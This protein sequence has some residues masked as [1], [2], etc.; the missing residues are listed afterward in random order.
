MSPAESAFSFFDEGSPHAMSTSDLV[1]ER[2]RA[3]TLERGT[4]GE[5]T[6]AS[7]NAGSQPQSELRRNKS[8]YY[9]EVFSYREPNLSPR[10]R[11][12]KDSVITAEI[13]T[14]VIVRAYKHTAPHPTLMLT[15]LCVFQ[16]TDEINFLQ[17]FSQHLS[18]RYQRPVSSIFITLN[19]SECLLYAGTFDQAYCLTI[20][21]LPSQVLP[22][23]N[24]RNAALIQAFLAESLGVAATRGVVRFISIPEENLAFNGTTVFGQ[25]E[26]LQKS[27]PN[28]DNFSDVASLSGI[29]SAMQSRAASRVQSRRQSIS[30]PPSRDGYS[31]YPTTRPPSPHLRGPPIPTLPN[32]TNAMDRR[33]EKAQKVGKRR[34]FFGFF[35]R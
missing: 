1:E 4:P 22:T 14:N 3:K 33:A 34:S 35:V 15:N 8:Q 9:T 13:K 31:F 5:S 2:T 27:S 6:Y 25:I 24:K 29:R 32:G 28:K 12:S 18:Q 17:D 20:S 23:T 7:I 26:N 21:A 30:K 11:I 19:H 16:I 10:D